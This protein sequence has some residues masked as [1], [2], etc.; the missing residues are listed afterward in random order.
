VTALVQVLAALVSQIE[1]LEGELS[2]L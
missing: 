1:R 2:A